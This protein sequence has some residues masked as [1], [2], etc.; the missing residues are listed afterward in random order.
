MRNLNKV[1]RVV[2]CMIGCKVMIEE[3]PKTQKLTG[4]EF[5]VFFL[6]SVS[7]NCK[8]KIYSLFFILRYT[9]FIVHGLNMQKSILFFST[10]LPTTATFTEQCH[11][12]FFLKLKSTLLSFGILDLRQI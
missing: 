9:L 12:F 3:G 7:R 2:I 11:F 5:L 1:E 4:N 10:F 8:I 6:C